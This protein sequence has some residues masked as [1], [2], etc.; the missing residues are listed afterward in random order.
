MAFG[1][2]REEGGA[3]AAGVHG[4]GLTAFI[5]QGSEFEGKLAFKDTVRIDGCFTGEIKS[6]N[7]LI[8]G[9]T[10]EIQASIQ[11]KCVLISGTLVGDVVASQKVVLHK[12]ARVQGNLETPVLA[13]EDGAVF[14]GQVKMSRPEQAMREREAASLKAVDGGHK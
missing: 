9:E 5:D 6:E 1:R 10:G 4:G 12:T 13:I 11:S 7:T 8:V 14:N 2:S 3:P